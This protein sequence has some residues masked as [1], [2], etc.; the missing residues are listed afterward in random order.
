MRVRQRR[1]PAGPRLQAH[2]GTQ[3]RDRGEEPDVYA[4][5][6][7]A[8]V[9]DIALAFT[10]DAWSRTFRSKALSVAAGPGPVMTRH[11]LELLPDTAGGVLG[12]VVLPAPSPAETARSLPETLKAIAARHGDD[13]ASF[14]ALQLE[15][16]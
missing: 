3:P 9:D 2:G 5:P 7:A 12:S 14:E 6:V 1:I 8:G 10:A 4:V 16:A 15:Y 13:T 11:G